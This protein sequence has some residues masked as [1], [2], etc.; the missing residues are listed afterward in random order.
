[1][2]FDKSAIGPAKTEAF[3]KFIEMDFSNNHQT[4]LQ[5]IDLAYKEQINNIQIQI[6]EMSASEQKWILILS[7]LKSQ[8]ESNEK[9]KENLKVE[10]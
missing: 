1:M 4:L 3:I 8:I 5:D 10:K 9:L 6:A 7:N 2:E